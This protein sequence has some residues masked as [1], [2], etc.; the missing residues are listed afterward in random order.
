LIG[1]IVGLVIIALT[2]YTNVVS[3]SQDYAMLRVLG[4]RRRD[5]VYIVFLQSLYIAAIGILAGF[6]L[7]AGFLSGT[8]DSGLPVYVP[9][10]MGPG[11][12]LSALALCLLGSLLAMR[13]AV[14][15]EPA[16]VFR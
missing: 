12:A 1:A 4:A 9:W 2:M 13:R 14:N 5:V 15:I 3:K 11:L 7:L 8:R 6:T 10:F 16:S